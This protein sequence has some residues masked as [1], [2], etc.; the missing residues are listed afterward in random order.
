M[1]IGKSRRAS[2]KFGLRDIGNGEKQSCL[3]SERSFGEI[4]RSD[5]G[6]VMGRF[7]VGYNAFV[8]LLGMHP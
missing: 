8:E 7:R 6:K 2:R 1:V 4:V 3:V 5:G